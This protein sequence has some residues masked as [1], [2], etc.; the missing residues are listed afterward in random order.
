M[1]FVTGPT[2][3]SGCLFHGSLPPFSPVPPDNSSASPLHVSAYTVPESTSLPVLFCSF[4]KTSL[5]QSFLPKVAEIV[6]EAFYC[7][8][9]VLSS[10]YFVLSLP[11]GGV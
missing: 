10:N 8:D 7:P 2:N 1:T 3:C 4:S 5:G 11:V 9:T 6:I